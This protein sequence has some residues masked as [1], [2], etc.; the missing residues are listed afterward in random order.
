MRRHT[1]LPEYKAFSVTLAGVIRR[2]RRI[3]RLSTSALAALAGVSNDLI[4]S[5]EIMRKGLSLKTAINIATALGIRL[6]SLVPQ[7]RV[8][9]AMRSKKMPQNTYLPL[10]APAI[11]LRSTIV[12][13]RAKAVQT[14]AAAA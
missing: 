1:Q 4:M 12:R 2:W 8:K 14:K 5:V 6:D 13:Q 9:N 3:R 11:P 10:K 7:L